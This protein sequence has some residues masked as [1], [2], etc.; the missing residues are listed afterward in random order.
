MQSIIIVYRG[1][2]IYVK[3]ISH[4]YSHIHRKLVYASEIIFSLCACFV[5]SV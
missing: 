4:S 3:A 2:R 1:Q 5:N